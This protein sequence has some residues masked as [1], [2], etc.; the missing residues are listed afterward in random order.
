[1]DES[2]E[3]AIATVVA[4]GNSDSE[5]IRLA[6]LARGHIVR[7]EALCAMLL[8]MGEQHHLIWWH[9]GAWVPANEPSGTAQKLD[10]T[11]SG[12][13]EHAAPALL[14]A[15]QVQQIL[16]ARGERQ[17]ISAITMSASRLAH[18]GRATAGSAGLR[19]HLAWGWRGETSSEK[20]CRKI[21]EIMAPLK[22]GASGRDLRNQ[23]QQDG[24]NVTR[25]TVQCWL[26]TLIREKALEAAKY[27]YV[28]TDAGRIRIGLDP[29][30]TS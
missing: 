11:I 21:L 9:L 24:M 18:E 10:E 5:S 30:G 8:T 16:T 27:G 17:S 7:H 13:L 25:E 3:Q 2:T 14:T 20:G 1:M 26:S 4:S 29:E 22:T 28:I 15:H 23:L 19:G 12:L 6:L